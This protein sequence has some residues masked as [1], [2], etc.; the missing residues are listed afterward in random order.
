M[1]GEKLFRRE[2]QPS[3]RANFCERLYEEKTDHFVR[4]LPLRPASLTHKN[5]QRHKVLCGMRP[6]GRKD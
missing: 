6:L 4:V 2:G 1:D 3:R 5:P